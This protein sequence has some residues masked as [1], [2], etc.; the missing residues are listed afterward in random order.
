MFVQVK[1]VTIL[2]RGAKGHQVVIEA[3]EGAMFRGRKVSGYIF[4]RGRSSIRGKVC[5]RTV[6]SCAINLRL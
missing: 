1:K 5:G 6:S 4:N 3:V 2:R